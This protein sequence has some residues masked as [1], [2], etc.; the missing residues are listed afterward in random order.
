MAVF[1]T[2]TD[3]KEYE[4]NI[5]EFGIQAFSAMH[6][7]TYNDILR[8][9]RVE[10]WPRVSAQ[11]EYRIAALNTLE[12]DATKLTATQFVRSAVFHTLGYYIFTA[13]S[14]HGAEPDRFHMLMEYYKTRFRE[15]FNLVLADGIE[16][17]WDAGG[18]ISDS[19]KQTT[20]YNRLVR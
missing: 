19:E 10:W 14:Q 11:R 5:D 7:K 2:D 3:L 12:M 8:H 17:D 20:H 9:L 4:A 13:L 15:E 18:T 1:A 16:Y 6:T